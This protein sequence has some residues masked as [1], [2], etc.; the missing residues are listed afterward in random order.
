MAIIKVDNFA[1]I[2][3]RYSAR[4]IP[5]NGATR[6][7]NAKLLSGELR[8]LHEAQV[9][10]DFNPLFPPNPIARAYRIPDILTSPTPI[11]TTDSW[12]Y[13]YDPE[14]DFVRTPVANDSF[15][16]YYWT[17]DSY[18]L[19]GKPQYNTRARILANNPPYLLGIPTPVNAPVVTPPGGTDL[20]RA[21]V[22]TFIS[23]FGEEGPPSPPTLATGT[24]GSW[25]ITG[26]D[27]T[28]PDAAN[29]SITTIRIY[30][31]V[32]GYTSSEYYFVADVPLGMTTYSDIANDAVVAQNNTMPSLTWVAPPPGLK[33][34]VAHPGGFLVGFQGRDLYFSEPYRPHAW[35]LQY[36]QTCQTEIV[37]V[38]IFNNIVVV[39]TT[40]HPYVAEGMSPVNITM[41]K[42][43]SIDPCIS[44]RSI[45]TTIDGVYYASPQG[46]I[47]VNGAR[48]EL[49]SRSLFT[50]EEWQN[51]FSPTTVVAVPY[52]VQ[53]IAFDTSNTGF[54]FSPAEQLAP[55]T[56]LDRFSQVSCIQIDGYSGDVY[57]VQ[58]N[59]ALLWDPPASIP[60]YY[61]WTSKEYEVPNPLNFGAARLKFAANPVQVDSQQ[62]ADY[63]TF[64]TQRIVKPLNCLNLA[65]LN[66]V[67][68]EAVASVLPQIRNPIGGS[69]L[70]PVASLMNYAAQVQVTISMRD[71]ASKWNVIFDEAIAD[72]QIF[73]LPSGFKSDVW[74]VKLVG[75]VPV[76]NFV[77]GGTAK[78]LKQV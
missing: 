5:P 75:N 23:S 74:Q 72:E 31:T 71:L 35:P 14:V 44:R 24:L 70:F 65:V 8:G 61:T 64:N 51:F 73:R 69:P 36:V 66:G 47:R 27:T 57:I 20:T 12:I 58:K 41:E 6:A 13:F 32:P 60:Y 3:P 19:S 77:M 42:I 48:T 17:G 59:R 28:V 52:G 40:S 33:G 26:F 49:I 18:V 67:R 56:K 62:V 10:K 21:Y 53:Y 30:R 15:E 9:I 16:R 11:K 78:E 45:A 7:D 29:R 43:E 50:R 76:N 55:L 39:A 1:G 63:T 54:I 34:I 25:V 4:L 38:A 22:Y 68:V 2:A 37:G 46:I